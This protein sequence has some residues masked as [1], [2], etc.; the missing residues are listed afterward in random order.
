MFQKVSGNE[1]LIT[2]RGFHFFL[3]KLWGLL[4]SEK[5]LR[6]T[7]CVLESFCYRKSLKIGSGEDLSRFSVNVFCIIGKKIDRKPISASLN[8]GIERIFD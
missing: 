6:E 4:F 1:I 3:S 8:S 2:Q 7:F 5:L